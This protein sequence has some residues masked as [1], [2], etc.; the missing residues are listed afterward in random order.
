MLN[1]KLKLSLI[2]LILI[3]LIILIK[4]YN[5]ININ[6]LSYK[7]EVITS[8]EID[9]YTKDAVIIKYNEQGTIDYIINSPNIE[10]YKLNNITNIYLPNIKV[11]NNN[12][13]YYI[14]GN[15]ANIIPD[16]NQ[17]DLID[18]INIT[19]N[20]N[21]LKLTTNKLTF[22]PKQNYISN[23]VITNITYNKSTIIANLGINLNLTTNILKLSKVQGEYIAK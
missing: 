4:Y 16:N 10:H 8:N 1:N 19:N 22:L 21:N 14:T 6:K 13:T 17:I 5:I 18:N 20:I 12:N 11:Y 3:V 9:F 7:Q 23:N 2:I 15:L